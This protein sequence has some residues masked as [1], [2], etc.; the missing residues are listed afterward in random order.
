MIIKGYPEG[1][2]ITILNA[3]YKYPKKDEESGKWDDG[4]I[5]IVYRDNLTGEKKLEHIKNPD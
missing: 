5:D 3:T 2:D 1:S 4:S